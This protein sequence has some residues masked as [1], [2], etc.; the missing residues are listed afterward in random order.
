M[1]KIYVLDHAKSMCQSEKNY[2]N[3]EFSLPRL[4][5]TVGKIMDDFNQS[6]TYMKIAYEMSKISRFKAT[7]NAQIREDF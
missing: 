3:Y 6:C 2:R 1:Y 7:K 5:R 4:T